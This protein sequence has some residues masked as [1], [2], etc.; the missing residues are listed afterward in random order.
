VCRQSVAWAD[1]RCESPGEALSMLLTK[2]L[3][4]GPVQVQFG[5]QDRRR[6]AWVDL[7]IGRHLV[8]FDGR[9]KYLRV[10]EGGLAATSADEVVWREKQR[11][12]W[13]CGFKLG[14]SRLVWADVQPDRWAETQRR[15]LREIL[16]TNARFGVSTDDLAPYVIRR[17]R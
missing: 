7:R 12:D 6:V 8:E 1:G 3:G 11:Q 10:D 2:E 16:D 4:V 9:Q 17:S 14:M 13:L 15:V 5:L